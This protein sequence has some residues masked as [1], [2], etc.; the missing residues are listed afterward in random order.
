MKRLII[1]SLFLLLMIACAPQQE[2]KEDV[3][4]VGF[5]SPL[6]GPASQYGEPAINGAKLALEDINK[7]GINGKKLELIVEDGKCDSKEATTVATKLITQDNVKVILGGHCSPES[8][9]IAPIA[10][11]NKVILFASMTTSPDYSKSGDYIFRNS[12]VNTEGQVVARGMNNLKI[13][14]AA[15][16]VQ[17]TSYALPIR[18]AF[19]QTFNGKVVASEEFKGDEADFKTQLTK[20]KAKNPEAVFIIAQGVGSA[21]N[22]MKQMKELGIKSKRF[23]AAVF[24]TPQIVEALGKDADGI[25]FATLYADE[26]DPAVV[27]FKKR[28][29]KA[30]GTEPPL[31]AHTLDATA[32]VYIIAEALEAC[33]ENPECIKVFLYNYDNKKT[34]AGTISI[35]ENGDADK[36]FILKQIKDG[37]IE[38]YSSS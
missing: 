20:I 16:I 5:I 25:I 6:T 24:D 34:L 31:L 26:S 30:Y 27:D 18:D 11:Q 14:T 7:K 37:K 8:L 36:P 12:P 33:G 4:R 13:K 9:A 19:Q 29:K 3:I 2:Q 32:A 35:D 1:F 23:G 28:Y 21:I 17:Q 22:I 38:I 10:E 15:V